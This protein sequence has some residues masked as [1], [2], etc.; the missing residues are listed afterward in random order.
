[1]ALKAKR[2]SR[3][4][5]YI[6]MGFIFVGLLGFGATSFTGGR[7][8]VASVGDQGVDAS[9]YVRTIQQELRAQ[10]AQQGRAVTFAEAQELGLDR[11][12]LA[13]LIV[14][15]SLDWASDEASISV[16]DEEVAKQL[17]AIS[18]FQGA[19]GSFDRDAYRFAL[20]NIGMSERDFEEDLRKEAARSIVQ[21]AIVSGNE[22]SDTYA[23]TLVAYAQ[24]KRDFTWAVLTDADMTTGVPVPTEEDLQAYYEENIAQFTRP[25]TKVITYAWV[26]PDM[27]VDSVEVDEE[28]LRASYEER[29][30]EFNMPERRLVERLVFSSEAEAL[31]A[32]SA[33]TNGET[34]FD[35][36]VAERGLELSD[37]DLGIVTVEDLGAAGDMVF[38]VA[39]GAVAGPAGSDLGPALFRVNAELAAQE[40]PFEDAIPMLRDELVLD[41]ARRVIEGQAEEYD[42]ELAAG[43]TLEELAETTDLEL[44]TIEWA[45]DS[46]DGIS[47]YPAFR[48]IANAASQDD[49]PEIA[50]LGDGGVFALRIDEIQPKAPYPF[51]NVRDRVQFGWER[52]A[53]TNALEAEAEAYV[54]RLNAGESFADL[55]LTAT[56]ETGYLR[57]TSL[58]AL[59]AGSVLQVFDLEDDQAALMRGV[60]RVA[61]L[62]LDGVTSA[63]LTTEDAQ[64]M[65]DGLTNQAS[66]S[67]AEDLYRAFIV[68]I[69]TR[70]GVTEN[71][72]AL[73][74]INAQ[75]Q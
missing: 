4:F 28:T 52:E 32:A 60:S 7:Q 14:N 25:E 17:G 9:T 46:E 18:A 1:M 65:I 66:G 59:P 70:A 22:M 16:G 63:D 50:A 8:D 67:L 53:T 2:L 29:R 34:T 33:I 62:Q 5:L 38:A 43:A 35:D 11:Q 24:E 56:S 20:R 74:Q 23:E 75:I 49:Y 21:G 39:S 47:G 37:V 19:D 45:G 30:D 15:A 54:A 10:Q 71:P 64:A 41:R 61:I 36:L 69:Q 26:T 12:V 27:I 57:S 40:T 3:V 68:N 6:L 13:Q 42:N 72:T 51:E 48:E 73:R 58:D 55:G 44:G 31:A